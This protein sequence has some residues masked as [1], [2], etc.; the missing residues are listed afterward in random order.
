MA[1]HRARIAALSALIASASMP[2][3]QRQRVSDEFDAVVVAA[4]TRNVPRRHLIQLL[5]ATRGLDSGT[6]QIIL[7]SGG[8][9]QPS[10][11]AMLYWLRNTGIGGMTLPEATRHHYQTTIVDV[12]NRYVHEAGAFPT[13]SELL[14]LLSEME[15]CLFDVLSL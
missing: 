11:G 15:A 13:D 1:S 5:H 7:S 9:L 8:T 3:T 14:L 2:A 12:R 4:R 6:S 10:L